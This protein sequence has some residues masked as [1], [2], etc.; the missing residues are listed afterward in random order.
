MI[1][2]T[3]PEMHPKAQGGNDLAAGF[4][5]R[6]TLKG[7]GR[8]PSAENTN[9]NERMAGV[10]YIGFAIPAD[11]IELGPHNRHQV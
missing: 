1:P 5:I 3:Q 9:V 8:R 2:D 11:N 7:A 10:R 6:V 4:C